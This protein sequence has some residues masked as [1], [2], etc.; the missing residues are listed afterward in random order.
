M[1][2]FCKMSVYFAMCVCVCS[3]DFSWPNLSDCLI[4]YYVKVC[5]NACKKPVKASQYA[6]HAGVKSFFSWQCLLL[7]PDK[8]GVIQNKSI[9]IKW[10]FGENGKCVLKQTLCR[11]GMFLYMMSRG[12]PHML[13]VGLAFKLFHNIWVLK[14]CHIG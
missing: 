12:A 6:A 7:W 14:W 11:W 3:S 1:R 2:C 4:F 9:C 8:V 5:C 10:K 13:P